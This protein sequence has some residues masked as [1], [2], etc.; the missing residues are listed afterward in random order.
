MVGTKVILGILR[1]L[2]FHI[3][4][5]MCLHNADPEWS[6]F[7]RNNKLF[8]IILLLNYNGFNGAGN[9][10]N[11]TSSIDGP[12]Q[13]NLVWWK[14]R[15]I[16][17]NSIRW[18]GQSLSSLYLNR[19]LCRRKQMKKNYWHDPLNYSETG[20]RLFLKTQHFV[21]YWTNKSNIFPHKDASCF[22]NYS[23]ISSFCLVRRS[24]P[25]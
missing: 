2:L 17:S 20:N 21:T 9:C 1:K 10:Q 11:G 16:Y 4:P 13:R 14:F 22:F 23:S 7:G 24:L 8:A 6:K 12:K 5:K 25:K 3:T 18:I 15:L 19:L